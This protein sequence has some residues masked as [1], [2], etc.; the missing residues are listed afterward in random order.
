MPM[1]RT[2]SVGAI[3]LDKVLLEITDALPHV[4]PELLAVR[5]LVEQLQHGAAFPSVK[6]PVARVDDPAS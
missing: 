2:K 6:P 4:E 1:S 5:K 3:L